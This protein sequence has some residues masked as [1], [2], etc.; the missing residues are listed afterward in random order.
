MYENALFFRKLIPRK[1]KSLEI[2]GM[3]EVERNTS[4]VSKNVFCAVQELADLFQSKGDYESVRKSL[5]NSWLLQMFYDQWQIIQDGGVLYPDEFDESFVDR[6]RKEVQ[7]PD[8][9][10][11]QNAYSDPRILKAFLRVMGTPELQKVFLIILDFG[12]K[13][14]NGLFRHRVCTTCLLC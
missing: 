7:N 12:P 13:G 6:V 8:F 3:Q 5:G 1:K 11:H 9:L 10:I 4:E 14:I 2:T